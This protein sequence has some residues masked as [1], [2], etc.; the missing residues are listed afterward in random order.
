VK[1]KIEIQGTGY[2][3]A[4]TVGDLE[5]FTRNIRTLGGNEGDPVGAVTKFNGRVRSMSVE[6]DTNS[7]GRVGTGD[8]QQV[9]GGHMY[10]PEISKE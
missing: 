9:A 2:K 5:K 4:V 6:F 7:V 8:A 10:H 1:Q 3:G